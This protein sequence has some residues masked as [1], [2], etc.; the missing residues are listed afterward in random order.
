MRRLFNKLLHVLNE[1]FFVFAIRT[2]ISLYIFFCVHCRLHY[3]RN[4]I[5]LNRIGEHDNHNQM[6]QTSWKP[7]SFYSSGH[8]QV[9]WS[10]T[11]YESQIIHMWNA[12]LWATVNL[13]SNALSVLFRIILFVSQQTSIEH[14]YSLCMWMS[15]LFDDNFLLLS[16]WMEASCTHARAWHVNYEGN[17]YVK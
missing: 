1:K 7:V 15:M 4:W 14:F 10:Q 17:E 6:V 2:L 12:N 8:K 3:I 11:I 5:R 13:L 16:F 9:D